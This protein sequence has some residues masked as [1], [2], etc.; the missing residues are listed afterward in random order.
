MAVTD[1]REGHANLEE[2]PTGKR[3]TQHARTTQPASGQ[4][5]PNVMV[6]VV[7]IAIIVITLLTVTA[8]WN[9]PPT[10]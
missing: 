6:A 8:I 10:V 4:N 2:S 5:L 3:S 9:G 7:I 1:R